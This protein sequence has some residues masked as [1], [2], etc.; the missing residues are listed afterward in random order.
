MKKVIVIL[1][2]LFILL[3]QISIFGD[4]IIRKDPTSISPINKEKLI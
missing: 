4:E 1:T 2:L 3:I